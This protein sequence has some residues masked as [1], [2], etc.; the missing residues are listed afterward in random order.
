MLS[1]SLDI[2]DMS[3]IDILAK[4]YHLIKHSIV[5]AEYLRCTFV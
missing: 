5:V 3:I 1:L 2:L 4:V